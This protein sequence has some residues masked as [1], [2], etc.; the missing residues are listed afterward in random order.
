MMEIFDVILD[1]L[2]LG[3]MCLCEFMD[4]FMRFGLILI[5][6]HVVF[7]AIGVLLS[8]NDLVPSLHFQFV[9]SCEAR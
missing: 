8:L 6:K 7:L 4:V 2:M 9:R 5:R 1:I 3:L